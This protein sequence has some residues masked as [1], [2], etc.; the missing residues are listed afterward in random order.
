MNFTEIRKTQLTTLVLIC[1]P[2]FILFSCADDDADLTDNADSSSPNI[3]LIIADDLG[4]DAF[5]NYPGI[6]SIRANTPILDSLALNGVTFTNFWSSP[7]CAPTRAALLTGKFGFRTGVGGVQNPQTATLSNSEIIIQQ[8]LADNSTGGYASA[9]IGKWHVSAG[10]NLNAPDNFGVDYYS[11]IFRGAVQDYYNWTQTSAG[12]QTDITTYTTT[13]FVNQ[14]TDW[15]DQQSGPFFLW[16]AFNAPHTPF[17]LPP[18]DL[19][20]DKSLVDNQSAINSDPL[21]YYL[22][23]IEAMDTEIAR[24]I[25]SLSEEQR[26]NTVFIFMGDNGTPT[27]VVQT[28]YEENGAK[29]TLFQGGVNVP[30]IISGKGITR[31]NDMETAMVQVQ[32]LFATIADLGETGTSTY[33]DGISIR[34]LLSSVSSDERAFVY[35]EQFGNTSTNNDG[36]A[37]RNDRYKLIERSD[38]SSY[39]YDLTNDP[40]EQNNLLLNPLSE[41]SQENFDEL[42]NIQAGL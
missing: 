6:T 10:S 17:H 8:Y 41:L 38:E 27:Q 18:A 39:L 37:I 2:F 40:F 42:K 4:W 14:S 35:T 22:A 33:Q 24:L 5:G 36:Y 16:L 15:I 20:T 21:P 32:D 1:L 23:S 30:L 28:P 34:P 26:E 9:V 7:I 25:G 29:N 3:V 11:G 12:E 31:K 13:H 19:I